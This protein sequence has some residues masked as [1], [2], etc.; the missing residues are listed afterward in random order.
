M[1]IVSSG[2]FDTTEYY[3]IMRIAIVDVCKCKFVTYS[4]KSICLIWKQILSGKS[5]EE[6]IKH[7]LTYIVNLLFLVLL[8][9]ITST[10]HKCRLYSGGAGV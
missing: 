2:K 9:H 1:E 4:Q 8:H 5:N 7:T 6:S 3:V 10:R